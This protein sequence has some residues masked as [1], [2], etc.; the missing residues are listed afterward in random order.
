MGTFAGPL[1]GHVQVW[2]DPLAP[3]YAG[4][5][6]FRGAEDVVQY[7][8]SRRRFAPWLSP[9]CERSLRRCCNHGDALLRHA[10]APSFRA[11]L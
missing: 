2:R 5:N 9:Q 7:L 1:R 6:G 11:E 3:R 10:A 8:D 4:E